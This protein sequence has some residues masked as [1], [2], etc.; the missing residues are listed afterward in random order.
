MIKII[1]PLAFTV[2][3]LGCAAPDPS[4]KVIKEGYFLLKEN[5]VLAVRPINRYVS[6]APPTCTYKQFENRHFAL[7]GRHKWEII[8]EKGTPGLL[9]LNG[10]ASSALNQIWAYRAEQGIY[11]NFRIGYRRPPVDPSV[12]P[13]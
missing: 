9:A 10:K 4:D 8:N 6:S 2:M 12:F 3:L 5:Y 11:G 1:F 7:C 13:D